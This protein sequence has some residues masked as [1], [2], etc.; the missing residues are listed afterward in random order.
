MGHLAHNKV[1]SISIHKSLL[2]VAAITIF[3]KAVAIA[4]AILQLV[5]YGRNASHPC[6]AHFEMLK[7]LSH[8]H[9]DAH[10][11]INSHLISVVTLV[12]PIRPDL[13]MADLLPC[14]FCA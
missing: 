8:E 4:A 13:V 5:L 9:S 12:R 2:W 11:T 6:L 10:C 14:A 7:R 1:L 3:S